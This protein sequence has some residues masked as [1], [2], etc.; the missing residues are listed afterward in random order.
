MTKEPE[1]VTNSTR[2]SMLAEIGGFLVTAGLAMSLKSR[3]ESD[4]GR[5]AIATCVQISGDL[6]VGL[7]QLIGERNYYSAAALGRQILEATWL[8]QYFAK[9]PERARFW[10]NATDEDLRNSQDFRPASLRATTGSSGE[11]YGK[12]CLLGGHPRSIARMLL[13]GSHW[14][15][16]D[17]VIDLSPA[18]FDIQVDIRALL[19]ADSLQ[20]LY[21]TVLETIENLDLDAFQMLGPIEERTL[22]L[23]DKLVQGLVAWRQ[24]DPLSQVGFGN[25]APRT[26]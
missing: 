18:G 10:L 8:I 26:T 24:N 16:E 21:A 4:E 15:R 1:Q 13:P 14:R 17:E 25:E 12:H 9:S 3:R 19:L 23:T 5:L 2:D 11:V 22:D 7:R 20:H 6:A